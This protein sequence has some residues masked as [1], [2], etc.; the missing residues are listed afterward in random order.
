MGSHNVDFTVTVS[1]NNGDT[2][3]TTVAGVLFDKDAVTNT[4]TENLNNC[5][6]DSSCNITT[7]AS[8]AELTAA[9]QVTF[10]YNGNASDWDV[11]TKATDD[12]GTV[13][14]ANANVS[15]NNPALQGINISQASLAY[16]T[17]AAGD[18]SLAKTT[19]MQNVGN[20]I[21]D[22]YI[23]GDQ[24]TCTDNAACIASPI[25]VGQQKWHHNDSSFLWDATTTLPGPYTLVDT[26]SSTDDETG[27]L[28]RDILVKNDTGN[29]TE[30]ES[31][32]WTLKIPSTQSSG[33]Y[34]GSNTFSATDS[35][36]CSNAQ[37][38]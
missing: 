11:Q 7:G 9:C 24:M 31:I 18:A 34:T 5:Y 19:T 17:V 1:D 20:Q 27:C 8:D 25:A 28:N 6:I 10:Q 22:I 38:Y 23:D 16:G 4:C 30:E 37:S 14:F 33:A 15:L 29:G 2:D 32:Y 35:S 26:T 36:T 3:V 13:E 12:L 21:L